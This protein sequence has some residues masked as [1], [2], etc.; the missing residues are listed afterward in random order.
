M[1]WAAPRGPAGRWSNRGVRGVVGGLG[2]RV[3]GVA[4]GTAARGH[5]GISVCHYI[6]NGSACRLRR[7]G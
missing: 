5:T 2:S 4:R 7:R 3:H 1:R 6:A